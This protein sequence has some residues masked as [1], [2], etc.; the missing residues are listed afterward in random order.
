MSTFLLDLRYACRMLGR[1]LGFAIIAVL[2]LA[3]GIAANTTL[4]SVVNGVLLSPLPYSHSEQLVSIN[5]NEAVPQIPVSY[6]T[7][8]TGSA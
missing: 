6:P 7:F 3:L 2:T 4:F 5:S 8:L 1:S